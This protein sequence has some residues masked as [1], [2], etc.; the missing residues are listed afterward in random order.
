MVGY[1]EKGKERRYIHWLEPAPSSHEP[2]LVGRQRGYLTATDDTSSMAHQPYRM[3][4]PEEICKAFEKRE[5]LTEACPLRRRKR[6][7]R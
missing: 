5:E 4:Y 7:Y 1:E 2:D 6:A 3:S